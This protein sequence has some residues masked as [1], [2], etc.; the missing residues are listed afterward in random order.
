MQDIGEWMGVSTVEAGRQALER[1]EFHQAVWEATSI[2][3]PPYKKKKI[4][5][6]DVIF[7]SLKIFIGAV[8]QNGQLFL[9]A[10]FLRDLD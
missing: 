3:D 6:E 10:T 1:G 5:R 2:K 4:P 7:S 8:A 9:T